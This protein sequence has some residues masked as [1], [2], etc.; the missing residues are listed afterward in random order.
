MVLF[1]TE[2]HTTHKI[3]GGDVWGTFDNFETTGGFDFTVAVLSGGVSCD[4]IAVNNVIAAVVVE[5][6]WG[7]N[8]RSGGDRDVRPFA[9][10][11]GGDAAIEI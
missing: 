1:S 5:P 11:D 3:G 7:S 10:V 8:V 2:E 4:V 6:G 9:S